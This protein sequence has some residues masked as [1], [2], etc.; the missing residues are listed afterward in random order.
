MWRGA[1][2][3]VGLG[4][5]AG[6][7]LIACAS[8]QTGGSSATT[9]LTGTTVKAHVAVDGKVDIDEI[10]LSKARAQAVNWDTP[11]G[12]ALQIVP[13]EPDAQWPLDVKCSGGHCEGTQRP[14]AALGKH[15]YHTVV[16]TAPGTDP[17]IIIEG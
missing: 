2:Q 10:H 8:A 4:F 13:D 16:G 9:G 1:L 17:V 15:P 11:G 7:M 6:G 12:E 14:G 5:V 3:A